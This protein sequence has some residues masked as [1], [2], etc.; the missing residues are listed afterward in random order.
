MPPSVYLDWNAATPPEPRVLEAVLR[1][2]AELWANPSSPHAQGRRARAAVEEA[3]ESVARL[4]GVEP[5][6]VTCVSSGTEALNLAAS[7]LVRA[8]RRRGIERPH[9]LA[10]AVE[11]KALLEPLA[12]LA[13]GGEAE[14]ELVPVDSSGIVHED[15]LTRRLRPGRTIF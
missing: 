14:V 2:Q 8:A 6:G 4:L 12:A 1:A 13:R 5:G 15:E 9:V 10:S 7:G 11:H 3:R